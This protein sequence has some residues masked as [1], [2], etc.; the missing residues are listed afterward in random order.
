MFVQQVDDDLLDLGP[1]GRIVD[2]L[3]VPAGGVDQQDDVP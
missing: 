1:E 3:A 2:P